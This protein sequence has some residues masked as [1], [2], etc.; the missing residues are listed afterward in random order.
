MAASVR[1]RVVVLADPVTALTTDMTAM[2]R[3]AAAEI[4]VPVAAASQW[5]REPFQ[6]GAGIDDVERVV[7]TLPLYAATF[8]N[9]V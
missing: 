2:T 5:A 4:A 1:A 3:M 8:T 6:V 9:I 7:S